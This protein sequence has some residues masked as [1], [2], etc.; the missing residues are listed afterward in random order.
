MIG[1]VGVLRGIVLMR[2]GSFLISRR[3]CESIELEL[4]WR[5]SVV[6]AEGGYCE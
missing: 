3:C 2:C 4:L 6:K 1:L 5:A